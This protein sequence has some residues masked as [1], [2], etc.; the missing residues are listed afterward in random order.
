LELIKKSKLD[1][2]IIN[3]SKLPNPALVDKILDF[4]RESTTGGVNK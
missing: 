4:L 2:L 1:Y 3:S